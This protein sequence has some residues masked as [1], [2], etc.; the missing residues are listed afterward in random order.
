V[1][2][3]VQ[4]ARRDPGGSPAAGIGPRTADA[5][6]LR[7]LAGSTRPLYYRLRLA[8]SDPA[9]RDHQEGGHGMTQGQLSV[10]MDALT[11]HWGWF[12]GLG[13][14]L[15]LLGTVALGSAVLMTIASVLLFGTL[16]IVGGA[17]QAVHAFWRRGWNGFFIDLLGGVL[18]L[19]V[20]A[21]IAANPAASAVALTLL[22]AVFLI[23]GGVFRIAGAL[24][25]RV[26]HRPWL[27]LYGIVN[28]VL[29]IMIWRQWPFSGLWVIG[30]F[31]GIDMIFNGWS[32]VMLAVSAKNLP[33][34][35]TAQTA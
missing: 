27:L 4:L 25:V 35:A 14:V 15:I 11:Q 8:C 24:A 1:K 17:L 21:M 6:D 34:A 31:V 23:V 7:S 33:R 30:L 5:L 10:G 20:G 12:L 3:R 18:Y 28:L 2:R 29:G 32:L 9:R 16:L 22:I 13:I 26:Q 19:V